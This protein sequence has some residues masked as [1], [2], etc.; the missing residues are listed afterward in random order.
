MHDLPEQDDIS[1]H[2]A[3]I[4]MAGRFPGAD[5][6]DAFWH[7][8]AEGLD[9][10]TREP[11]RPLRATG[12]GERTGPTYVPARGPLERPEWFDAGYFGYSAEE[13]LLIDPQQR[14]F[15][16]CAVAALEH[17][18]QD[19]DRHPGPIGVYG[20]ST[21]TAY[22]QILRDRL[23]KLPG[24]T[25]EDIL[26]GTAPDFLVARTAERLGLRGPA[27]TVQSACATVLV[28]V[29]L[30]GQGLLSGDCDLALAG[31]VAVHAPPKKDGY[32]EDGILSPDGVCRPFDA[33]GEGTVAA[34]GVGI[35]VLKRLS[36]ALADG[37]RV[38][39]VLRGSAV[40]NDGSERVGFTA[41]SVEGQ[42]AAVRTAQLAAGTDAGTITYVETHGTATPLGDPIEITALTR[43]FREDT[44]ERGYC[45]VG[46]VKSNVGHTDAAAGAAGL[47]KT[48]L[49]LEH[50]KIPPSLH[51]T[52]PN[53]QVDFASSPFRVATRSTPGSRGGPSAARA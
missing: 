22:A 48:V 24:V 3:V 41:P 32:T 47:I 45:A 25:E 29:H 23:E 8:L 52:T 35:V 27:I 21:E 14:V 44:D 12:A 9:T 16:E 13:A 33:R 39:A 46:S 5:D 40:T 43:A 7:N 1:G 42:A 19:P 38:H 34:N 26:L 50:G 20:G 2:I 17:A 37:D 28:A 10:L 6:I 15:L 31:G 18:G 36:D 49:A 53:P 4:G 51:F 30:A 11:A